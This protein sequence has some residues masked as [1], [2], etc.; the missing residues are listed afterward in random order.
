MRSRKVISDPLIRKEDAIRL[1][2][3]GAGLARILGVNR[4]SVHEWGEFLPPLHAYRILQI[5]PQLEDKR[6]DEPQNEETDAA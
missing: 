6:D 2:H 3:S 5:F 4:A 1:A